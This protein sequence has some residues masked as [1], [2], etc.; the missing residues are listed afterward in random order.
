M[1]SSSENDKNPSSKR[2]IRSLALIFGLVASPLVTSGA[3]THSSVPVR[4]LRGFLPV[5]SVS[6][7]G[8]GPFDFLVDTGTNT[9]LI[10]PALAAEL[11]LAPADR[12]WITT[13]T[14]SEAV[15]RY[16]AGEVRVGEAK[17]A[18]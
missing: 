7:N 11:D 5:V 4:T 9:T 2:W 15:P 16:F 13:L 17:L 18:D 3:S 8:R 12:L 14:G 1:A 6:V 10:E